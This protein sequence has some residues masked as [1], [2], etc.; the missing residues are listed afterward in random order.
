MAP[1]AGTLALLAIYSANQG[2]EH[3]ADAIGSRT[4]R[5][6]FVAECRDRSKRGRPQHA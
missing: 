4:E 3:E 2:A 6:I 1:K 5:R